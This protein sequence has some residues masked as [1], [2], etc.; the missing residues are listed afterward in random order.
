[1]SAACRRDPRED[2]DERAGHVDLDEEVADVAPQN[3]LDLET[4]V[5]T[6][7][8]ATFRAPTNSS[9]LHLRYDK[10]LRCRR[11]TARRAVSLSVEML[12]TAGAQWRI[13][14]GWAG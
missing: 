11:G 13:A 12:P 9:R 2:D 10:K 14:M 8:H 5:R 1:M 3:E 6:C 4:R 7:K